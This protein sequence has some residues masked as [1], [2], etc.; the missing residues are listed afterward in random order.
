MADS[1]DVA[2]RHR[3]LVFGCVLL[4]LSVIP[5]AIVPFTPLLGLPNGQLAS[6][7]AALL[8]GAEII[9]AVAIA[10]LG[11]ESYLRITRRLRPA[12]VDPR[13]RPDFSNN[14]IH[15]AGDRS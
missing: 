10:V 12:R 9:G 4:L 2:P 14:E 5:W 7:V 13:Q 6:V 11:R 15:G 1:T 8:I 3:R